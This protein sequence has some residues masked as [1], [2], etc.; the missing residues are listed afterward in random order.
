M[1]MRGRMT[2]RGAFAGAIGILA[3]CALTAAGCGGSGSSGG[4]GRTTPT[5]QT[6]AQV[7][8]LHS[9]TMRGLSQVGFPME[10][11][12]FARNGFFAARYGGHYSVGGPGMG[13]VGGGG[14]GG[15]TDSAAP[16]PPSPVPMVGAFLNNIAGSRPATRA[17]AIGRVTRAAR[18]EPDGRP[19]DGVVGSE[20][21]DDGIGRP[22]DPPYWET[23]SFYYDYYLGLWVEVKDEPGRSRYSL[24]EDEAK[25]RPAG[26]IETVHPT[27]WET[28]PQ[29]YTH[30]YEFTAGF[31]AGSHGSTESVTNADF[32]GRSTYENLYS[33][34]WKDSG[35]SNWSG[36]GDYSWTSR[37]ETA[38]GKWTTSSGTFRANGSGGTRT[39]TSDGYRAVY[40]FNADGSGRGRIEGSDP[41][42][43]VT[44]AWDAYGNMTIQYADGTIERIPGWGYGY[45]GGGGGGVIPLPAED[46]PARPSETPPAPPKE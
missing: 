32:S 15:S 10:A 25:T 20:P 38:D 46:T 40:T 36:R 12:G 14:T 5:E 9:A 4:G 11:M 16:P 23:P 21:G 1:T 18:H 30:S 22:I 26:H 33:D 41:G 3:A 29:I 13:G 17:A 44:I 34:G 7:E 27:D 28:F 45:G 35:T 24:Y 6:R 43:P 19:G 2:R 8:S 31:L 42:M 39:E 37:T